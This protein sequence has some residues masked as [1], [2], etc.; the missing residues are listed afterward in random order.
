MKVNR[1]DFLT[2]FFEILD[3]SCFIVKLWI[4][5]PSVRRTPEWREE[6]YF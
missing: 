5:Q 3:N 2:L 1:W 4:R 6:F